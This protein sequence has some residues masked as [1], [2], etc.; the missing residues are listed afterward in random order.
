[1]SNTGLA[2]CIPKRPIKPRTLASLR[3]GFKGVSERS[4][5]QI[6]NLEHDE[7]VVRTHKPGA[8]ALRYRYWRRSQRGTHGTMVVRREWRRTAVVMETQ[9]IN[10][11]DVFGNAKKRR[12]GLG[13]QQRESRRRLV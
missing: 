9:A 5:T 11:L 3:S 6:R 10:G 4:G 8:K 13:R 7:R 1:M 12:R 2:W